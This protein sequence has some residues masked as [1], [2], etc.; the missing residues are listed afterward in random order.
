[1]ISA[2]QLSIERFGEVDDGALLACGERS[3]AQGLCGAAN[4]FS[5]FG[6]GV[7]FLEP[8]RPVSAH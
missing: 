5:V 4:I 3:A 2:P 7:E 1:M 8:I 6:V